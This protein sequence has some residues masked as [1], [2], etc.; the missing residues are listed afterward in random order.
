MPSGK[1][2]LW[3]AGLL[4]AGASLASGLLEKP[5]V[6][7]VPQYVMDY[8][9]LCY[10]HHQ[11]LYFPSDLQKHLDN[12]TPKDDNFNKIDGA[13]SP[14]SLTNLNKLNDYGDGG[15]N[16]WLTANDDITKN[17]EWIKGAA[18]DCDGKASDAIAVAVIM[19]DKGDDNMDV[20]FQYFYSYNWG[21]V[22]LKAFNAGNHVGDWEQNMIRFEKGKPTY[23]W[24][25]QHG[26]GQ[27]FAYDILEKDKDGQ[28]F[29]NYVANGSHANY[30]VSGSHDHTI[31]ELNLGKGILMDYT[32]GPK[33]GAKLWD[34]LQ[35]AY[36]YTFSNSTGK[37]TFTSAEPGKYPTEYLDYL[38]KWG[39]KQYPKS[40]KRQQEILGGISY[41]FVGGPTG[42][43]DKQLVRKDVC[44]DNGNPCILRHIIGP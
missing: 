18:P 41:K 44:P 7:G 24:Y 33:D 12:T 32:D 11:E 13:P 27:A 25:S 16:V 8:A 42:P 1:S 14:L 2:I 22:V 17:P 29:I 9:P 15:K 38:G 37:P 21:G 5:K 34:P 6:Q 23:V 40:D 36:F 3:H 43:I 19:V 4:A 10:L 28:R 39:D 31:P 35:N 30:A 20:F 26:N